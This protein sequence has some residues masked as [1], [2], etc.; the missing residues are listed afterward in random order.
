MPDLYHF[1]ISHSEVF[2]ASAL[3]I[4]QNNKSGAKP[5]QTSGREGSPKRVHLKSAVS[6]IHLIPAGFPAGIPGIGELI[7]ISM[8]HTAHPRRHSMVRGL[9]LGF[10]ESK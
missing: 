4:P 5:I 3:E 2:L 8:Q 10:R 1:F 7:E 9:G 6:W